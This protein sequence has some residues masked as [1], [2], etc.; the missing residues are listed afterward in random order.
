MSYP[1]PQPMPD[2][3]QLDAARQVQITDGQRQA[4]LDAAGGDQAKAQLL[5]NLLRIENRGFGYPKD[6]K[7]LVR[8]NGPW[9]F[10][11]Q[12]WMQFGQGDFDTNVHDFDAGAQA[13]SR[14]VDWIGRHFGS[15]PAVVAAY[16][17]GGRR[18]AD[19]VTLGMD[20]PA[21]E[22]QNYVRIMRG[23]YQPTSPRITGTDQIS[24]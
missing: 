15:D 24:P 21:Q 2:D 6:A 18:A 4:I 8:A 11:R 3:P 22:T 7:S 16:Y 13:A 20:P 5:E 10:T 1:G 17:N 14:M 12:A 23:L 9:Q 19:H